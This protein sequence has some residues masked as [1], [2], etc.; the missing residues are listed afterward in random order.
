MATN[1]DDMTSGDLAAGGQLAP[2]QGTPGKK[3]KKKRAQPVAV[4]LRR[5]APLGLLEQRAGSGVMVALWVPADV[6]AA[7]AVEGGE[8]A[9]EM[10]VTL[11]Y[12]GKAD[13]LG[14]VDEAT[15]RAAVERVAQ[16]AVPLE[17]VVSGIGR[18]VGGEQD[19]IYASVDVPGLS[20]L[21]EQLVAELRAAG[22]APADIHGFDPHITLAYVEPGADSPAARP[23]A[24]P[25]R[26]DA[27]ELAVAGAREA[28]PL[29]G[30][31]DAN[32][33]TEGVT[34]R[35]AAASEVRVSPEFRVEGDAT[36]TVRGPVYP[37][38]DP[39]PGATYSI[40]EI[41]TLVDSWGTFITARDLAKLKDD[42]MIR[43]QHVDRMHD[44][45]VVAGRVVDAVM[46]GPDAEFPTPTWFGGVRV[47]AS[48]APEVRAGKL[49]GFSIEIYAGRE[50]IAVTVRGQGEVPDL[51]GVTQHPFFPKYVRVDGER[52]ISID[53]MT[54]PRPVAKSLVDRP[55]IRQEFAITRSE[56][57]MRLA[58]DQQQEE[59][60][61]VETPPAPESRTDQPPAEEPSWFARGIDR[62]LA[63]IRRDPGV[64]GPDGSPP[65]ALVADVCPP[66]MPEA[67]AEE[68]APP[69]DA[70][71]PPVPPPAEPIPQPQEP[72][73]SLAARIVSTPNVAEAVTRMLATQA[74]PPA[75]VEGAEKRAEG[76][77]W[78][79]G[80]CW[81]GQEVAVNLYAM[82]GLLTDITCGRVLWRG[83]FESNDEVEAVI[84]LLARDYSEFLGEL[85]ELLVF[86]V[87]EEEG[88]TVE[89]RA[90]KRKALVAQHKDAA[91]SEMVLRASAILSPESVARMFPAESGSEQREGKKYSAATLKRLK[92]AMASCRATA[93]HLE[94]M[95]KEAE[96]DDTEQK[97]APVVVPPPAPSEDARALRAARDELAEAKRTITELRG[98]A[99]ERDARIVELSAAPRAAS[100]Q[101]AST[102]APSPVTTPVREERAWGAGFED[103][104]KFGA[105]K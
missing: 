103:A 54:A 28:F 69:P 24:W 26:F 101:P 37:S 18:F 5:R 73:M 61:S 79:F 56:L 39:T 59:P 77:E 44:N 22:I 66:V 67:R 34:V 6:A 85:R 90:E 57:V 31:A 81:E 32:A 74:G 36:C 8:P 93:E 7:L 102:S 49:R 12:L 92:D 55:A 9:G 71:P 80:A 91:T 104:T 96:P 42:Y 45:E 10:H 47:D 17:G 29:T 52:T 83:D 1:R 100:A 58:P 23:A 46:R 27:V 43:S 78:G 50:R 30:G 20:A 35:F 41:N 98:Q 75:P 38:F 2:T 88:M 33:R 97:T 87:A 53:R 63:A 99:V 65:P 48:I 82:L 62:L 84:R 19:V 14:A 86:E 68:P 72:V 70:T 94:A 60:V 95:V 105:G 3:P 4:E 13:A 76:D 21:R 64:L 25:L 40:D 15:A 51:T 89:A 16:S 11:A